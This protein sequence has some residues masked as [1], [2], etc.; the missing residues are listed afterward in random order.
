VPNTCAICGCK[1]HRNGEYAKHTIKGRSHATNHHYVARRFLGLSVNK[2]G[3]RRD[4]IFLEPPWKLD[5]ETGQ[6]CYECH[7]ELLHNPVLLP[8]DIR[9]FAE[10]IRL[11]KLNENTKTLSR[12][13]LA[14]RIKLL[15][16][17]F[18]KG[19][20]ASIKIERRK[21]LHL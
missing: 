16:E 4:R 7:E 17:V 21:S 6:F 10:L 12:V 15:H 13:K 1:I 5:N 14:E 2:K 3:E 20:E 8:K 19:I 18:E 11:R 9:R